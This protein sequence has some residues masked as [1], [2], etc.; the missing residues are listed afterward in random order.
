V[1]LRDEFGNIV[2]ADA[3]ATI[4]GAERSTSGRTTLQA[5]T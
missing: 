1:A 5:G 4:A 3:I 2:K